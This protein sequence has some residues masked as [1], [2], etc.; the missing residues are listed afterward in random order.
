MNEQPWAIEY[1]WYF[2]PPTAVVFFWLGYRWGKYFGS[3]FDGD[4]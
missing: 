1:F 4:S 3:H 2:A